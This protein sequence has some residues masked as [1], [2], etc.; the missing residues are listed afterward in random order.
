M[1]GPDDWQKVNHNNSLPH[2]CCANAQNDG[3]CNRSVDHY[4]AS[5]IEELRTLL[6]RYASVIGAAGLGIAG[7]QVS[8]FLYSYH[9]THIQLCCPGFGNNLRLRFSQ[10]HSQ[11]IRN[12]LI[13]F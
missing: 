3:S 5:C 7:F 6:V 1:N 13:F 11:G 9:Y 2:T 10:T 12:C 8:L 4:K